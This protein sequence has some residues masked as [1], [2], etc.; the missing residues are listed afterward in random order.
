MQTAQSHYARTCTARLLGEKGSQSDIQ[1]S[2]RESFVSQ[3]TVDHAL[4]CA[5]VSIEKNSKGHLS[6]T[7]DT[8]AILHLS[9]VRPFIF[10][11]SC[12]TKSASFSIHTSTLFDRLSAISGKRYIQDDRMGRKDT[13]NDVVTG[14]GKD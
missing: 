1:V 6:L 3:K 2:I 11:I 7:R 9:S 12:S 14:P 8:R 4:V 13:R 10:M 5:F